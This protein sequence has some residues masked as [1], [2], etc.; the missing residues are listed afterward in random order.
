MTPWTVTPD[1]NLYSWEALSASV[2]TATFDAALC[3]AFDYAPS[4]LSQTISGLSTGQ[5][6]QLSFDLSSQDIAFGG[7]PENSLKALIGSSSLVVNNIAT[8][9]QATSWDH[10][11]LDF[12]ATDP[13]A[14][15][16][17]TANDN[18]AAIYLTHVSLNAT[19]APVPEPESYLV[20]GIG[21]AGL[22]RLRRNK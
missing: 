19:S 13:T 6:Y 20:F 3:G 8:D 7:S 2:S 9:Y 14:L 16:S 1:P 4:T 22:V 12:K 18:S 5:W 17:F 21:L 11:L 15:L 10:H